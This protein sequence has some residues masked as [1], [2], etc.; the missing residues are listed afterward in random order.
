MDLPLCPKKPPLLGG[1]TY[2][3]QGKQTGPPY[4]RRLPLPQPVESKIDLVDVFHHLAKL[5]RLHQSRGRGNRRRRCRQEIPR[6]LLAASPLGRQGAEIGVGEV[7]GIE[8]PGRG[9]LGGEGGG[10]IESI[11]GAVLREREILGVGAFRLAGFEKGGIGE[12]P[13]VVAAP[14]SVGSHN[15]FWGL[16]G[17]LNSYKHCIGDGIGRGAETGSPSRR[18]QIVFSLSFFCYLFCFEFLS[19]LGCKISPFPFIYISRG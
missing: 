18:P 12:A 8:G 16:S 7:D 10:E 4:P 9:V 15:H 3:E 6:R 17:L 19:R 13:A 2:G 1:P 14:A 11:L 5:L